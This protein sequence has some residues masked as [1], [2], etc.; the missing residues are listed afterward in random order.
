[1]PDIEKVVKE[2]HGA[3]RYLEDKE[4]SDRG[5]SLHIDA[6]NDALALLEEQAKIIQNILLEKTNE[7]KDKVTTLQIE[8][9]IQEMKRKLE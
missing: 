8:S 9:Q 6:I 7:L 4:W 5:A 1:M 2:L 3:R